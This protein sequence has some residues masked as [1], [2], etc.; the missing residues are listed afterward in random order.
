MGRV[1]DSG[2]GSKEWRIVKR[3][4]NTL[5]C[6]MWDFEQPGGQPTYWDNEEYK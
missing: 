4:W 2:S 3:T 1:M 6:E 5:V